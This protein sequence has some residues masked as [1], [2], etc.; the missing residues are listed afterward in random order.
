MFKLDK[1]CCRARICPRHRFFFPFSIPSVWPLARHSLGLQNEFTYAR[2]GGR[3]GFFRPECGEFLEIEYRVTSTTK[4]PHAGFP[5]FGLGPRHNSGRQEVAPNRESR[6][7]DNFFFSSFFFFFY[8]SA[9]NLY[10]THPKTKTAT[11]TINNFLKL[12]LYIRKLLFFF[13]F[14]HLNFFEFY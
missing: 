2:V 1:T 5:L 14:K 10:C 8:S 11:T 7:L 12:C 6:S 13:F 4:I 9:T 3:K